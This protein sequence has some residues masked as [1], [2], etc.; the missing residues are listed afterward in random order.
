MQLEQWLFLLYR[1][2]IEM[3][4]TTASF[5]FLIVVSIIVT[6]AAKPKR[7]HQH[8]VWLT[9]RCHLAILVVA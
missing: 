4:F 9:N 7:V 6:S 1:V 5:D 3:T 8:T 2:M